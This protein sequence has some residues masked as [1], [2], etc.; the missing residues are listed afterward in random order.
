MSKEARKVDKAKLKPIYERNKERGLVL[1]EFK[2]RE[3]VTV[4]EVAE[5][6]HLQKWKV[7]KHL[8][9]LRQLGRVTIV[10]EK[11]DQFVY[12]LTR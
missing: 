2:A 3:R 4:E 10:G 12:A 1:K 9:A 5:A 8:I 11:D 6:T 7:L